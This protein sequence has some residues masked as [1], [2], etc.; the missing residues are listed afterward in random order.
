[1]GKVITYAIRAS[2]YHLRTKDLEIL[3]SD[4][5]CEIYAEHK[6]LNYIFT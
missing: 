4:A 3:S 6:C 1:M 2:S 5:K